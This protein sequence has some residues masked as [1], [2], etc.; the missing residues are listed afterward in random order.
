MVIAAEPVSADK[1][2]IIGFIEIGTLPSPLLTKKEGILY[3][4]CI[5]LHTL[6]SSSS[7]V[8]MGVLTEVREEKPYFGNV[9][10]SLSARRQG[11]GRTLAQIG[12]K[13]TET[14]WNDDCVYV[15]VKVNKHF[16]SLAF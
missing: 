11:I 14:K 2:N 10:V 8:V 16:P 15:A 12:L 1:E 13:M 6:V 5:V 9:A 3:R 4:L 7:V